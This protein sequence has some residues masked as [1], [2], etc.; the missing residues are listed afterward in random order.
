M[1]QCRENINEQG[2]LWINATWLNSM[3]NL[4]LREFRCM[5]RTH[6]FY[7]VETISL[8]LVDFRNN[9]HRMIFNNRSEIVLEDFLF[10]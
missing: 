7:E 3:P 4:H 8:S 5:V 6:T 2:V 10:D 9:S 1:S